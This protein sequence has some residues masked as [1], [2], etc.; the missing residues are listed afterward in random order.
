LA[1]EATGLGGGVAGGDQGPAGDRPHPVGDGGRVARHHVDVVERHPQGIGQDLGEHGLVTLALRRAAGVQTD[2]ARWHH[3]DPGPL[4]GAEPGHLQVQ[5]EP[6]PEAVGRLG[7]GGGLA[8]P[9]GRQVDHLDRPIEHLGIV[10]RVVL[11][12]HPPPVE[13]AGLVGIFQPSECSDLDKHLFGQERPGGQQ[14][15]LVQGQDR[16]FELYLSHTVSS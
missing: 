7:V 15:L 6:D 12:G 13:Q 4:E 14:L 5:R 9:D 10:A 16:E 1:E 2:P 11:L 8:L 3:V